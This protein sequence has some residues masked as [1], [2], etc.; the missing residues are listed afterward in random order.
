MEFNLLQW[1]RVRW[2][3][4]GFDTRDLPC[5]VGMRANTPIQD[6]VSGGAC[7]VGIGKVL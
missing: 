2:R 1:W 7:G 5:L 4:E 3:G 6:N